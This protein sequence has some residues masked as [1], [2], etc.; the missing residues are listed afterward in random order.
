[1][2]GVRVPV[3]H[4]ENVPLLK[5]NSASLAKAV[6]SSVAEMNRMP[7]NA[8]AAD[9]V[10][11]A[12]ARSQSG[13]IQRELCDERRAS[14]E[15]ADGTFDADQFESD[16]A[17]ARFNVAKSYAIFPGI[18]TLIQGYLFVRLDGFTAAIDY[19]ENTMRVLNS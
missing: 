18:P 3:Q 4:N 6:G 13:I 2:T 10:F 1:M 8:L 9:I 11:D 17:A 5:F 19:F 7:I 12:L 15:A 14:Y 16:L